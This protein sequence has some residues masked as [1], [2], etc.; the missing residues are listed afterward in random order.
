MEGLDPE[1]YVIWPDG[2]VAKLDDVVN[3]Q[4]EWKS[5]DFRRCTLEEATA[6]EE[7]QA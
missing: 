6:Y 5:D 1:D 7:A 2:D 3:G 4:Y